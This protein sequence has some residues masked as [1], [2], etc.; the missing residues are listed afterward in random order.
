M[1]ISEYSTHSVTVVRK[2]FT[3]KVFLLLSFSR[4]ER[5]AAKVE[6]VPIYPFLSFF[7]FLFRF[8]KI[9]KQVERTKLEE[10]AA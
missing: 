4:I 10:L 7:S 3:W 1:R 9:Q 5:R 2:H 6:I 8:L